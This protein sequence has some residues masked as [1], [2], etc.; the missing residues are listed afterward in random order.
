MGLQGAL[1]RLAAEV[2]EEN[3]VDA[4]VVQLLNIAVLVNNSGVRC[5]MCE[6][7]NDTHTASCPVPSL[8]EWIFSR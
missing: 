8:E 3:A 4:Q 5:Q 7:Q 6:G 2:E 1:N